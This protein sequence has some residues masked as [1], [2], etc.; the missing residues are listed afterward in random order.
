MTSS[1]EAYSS[2]QTI[3]DDSAALYTL[4][5]LYVQAESDD[6]VTMRVRSFVH[7]SINPMLFNDD[8]NLFM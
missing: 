7:A 8:E 4:S 5:T 1:Y 2:V 3:S 6:G